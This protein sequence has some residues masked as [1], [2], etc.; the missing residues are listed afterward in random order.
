[1]VDFGA[2][3]ETGI[4]DSTRELRCGGVLFSS[5]SALICAALVAC[6]VVGGVCSGP[7][8]EVHALCFLEGCNI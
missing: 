3:I 1:M 8:R 5:S 6:G 4:F 2:P 7:T